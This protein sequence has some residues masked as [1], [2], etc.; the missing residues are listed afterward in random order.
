MPHTCLLVDQHFWT[1]DI[2][3]AKSSR[4]HGHWSEMGEDDWQ[5]CYAT[6]QETQKKKT[7]CGKG[8]SMRSRGNGGGLGGSHFWRIGKSWTF[9]NTI[10]EGQIYRLRCNRRAS[11]TSPIYRQQYRVNGTWKPR[12]VL[13]IPQVCR[14]GHAWG[15]IETT[16]F[17]PHGRAPQQETL[18][19][20]IDGERR[21]GRRAIEPS[22][23][24]LAGTWYGGCRNEK[25]SGHLP[26]LPKHR[27]GCL[28]CRDDWPPPCSTVGGRPRRLMKARLICSEAI[29]VD[30]DIPR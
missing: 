28:L 30:H 5:V 1:T 16:G 23:T 19:P 13:A 29:G 2:S 20:R 17:C 21:A 18:Q 7:R 12:S 6:V 8:N 14:T 25:A 22:S 15:C 9:E 26:T 3:L 4:S 11:G 10:M 24:G 27:R